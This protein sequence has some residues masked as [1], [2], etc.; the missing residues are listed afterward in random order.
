MTITHQQ[1]T[2][3]EAFFKPVA[4]LVAKSLYTRPCREFSDDNYIHLGIH[5]VLE[6]S[7][8]GRGFLEEHGLGWTDSL[9]R[10][11]YFATLH[12]RRRVELLTDIN[13][14]VR[15]RANQT[16]PDRLAAI[17]E[18]ADYDCFAADGHWHKAATHD[19]R[20]DGVKM[21]VGHFYSLNLRTHS[22]RHLVAGEGLHEHDM[23][24]LKRVKPTGLRQGVPRGRRVIIIYDKAG[25]D[26]KYWKRCRQESAVYFLSR[27]KENM[28]LCWE[29]SID[30]DKN[31]PR[32]GGLFADSR[33][34]SREGH[35]LR[36][37]C[38]IDP[39]TGAAFEFLTNEMD[40]PAHVLIE[41]YRL[42][43]SVEKVFDEFKNKLGEKKAWGSSLTAK[44]TQAQFITLTHNLVLLYD[45]DLEERHNVEKTAEDKRRQQRQDQCA[46]ETAKVGH[47]APTLVLRAQRATQCCVKFI[48]WIRKSLR[49][50]AAEAAA[51]LQLKVLYATL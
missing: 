43:W 29:E 6:A 11:N 48:R 12:S 5:R 20:H 35:L 49:Y 16:L 30:F 31:D 19:P 14:S 22:V 45:H 15:R 47:P 32:N 26:F 8:S 51:V 4:G 24:A 3:N 17:T 44:E 10:S 13:D 42:R 9:T 33:A 50:Q 28:T 21:P 23:S 25:I 38:Y 40:L 1:D 27:V 37:I 7:P 36:V 18:L 41:L 2:V 39:I 34:K 46:E